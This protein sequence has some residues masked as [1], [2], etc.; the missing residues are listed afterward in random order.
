MTAPARI[1]VAEDE[2][3]VGKLLH[4]ILTGAGYE[5]ELVPNGD[6]LVRRAQAQP[7]DLII[8][9][10]L[11]PL[12]NGLEA[13]RQL[14]NDT[15]TAHLPMLIL[16]AI[17]DSSRI[18]EGF[19]NGADD[20]ITKPYNRDELLARV[21][22]HLRRAAQLP[23]RNPLTGLPGNVVIQAEINRQLAQQAT[24]ALLYIDLDN[25]KAFNDV[26]G[27][28]RG[29]RAIHLLADI[30][31][32][33]I[34]PGDF[35]GHIGGD[36]FV[37][38]HFGTDVEPLCQQ[39]IR[40]FDEQIRSLYDE[41]DLQRGYLLATD[42]YGIQRQ[43][44]IISLSIAVV[45]TYHRTFADVDEMSRV[46]AELKKAAK[47]IAGSSYKIDRRSDRCVDNSQVAVPAERRTVHSP[48]ALIICQ[49][50][51]ARAAIAATLNV[52][53]YRLFIADNEIAAQGLLANQ[54]QPKLVVA[55]LFDLKTL[56]LW[57]QINHD[58]P[59]IALARNEQEVT[60]AS[61]AG[62]TRVIWLSTNPLDL[63]DQLQ[64]ALGAL[65]L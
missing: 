59:L 43:F 65:S 8:A 33:Q 17:G 46:A 37:V 55:E 64:A 27:F 44:G 26:Y 40:V 23:Q 1:L 45:T 13:I 56:T 62:A 57:R 39:I 11:M 52:R 31:Q 15:R 18:V 14:R 16:T 58:T 3:D 24:F 50:A 20:Y 22:S 30:L 28:A 5:V 42:R 12:M 54:P 9:D 36:D 32:D 7:P 6:Q 61:T 47:Q 38:L 51:V 25:F 4:D 35:L 34:K 60:D 2:A 53:G 29:D 10:L 48:D 49:D 21:R 63:S 19:E 41:A